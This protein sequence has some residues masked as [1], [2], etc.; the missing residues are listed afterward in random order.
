M[1][2]NLVRV[3]NYQALTNVTIMP[4]APVVCVF[5]AN[6]QGK[7]SL[8]DAIRHALTGEFSRV[9]LKKDLGQLVRDGAETGSVEV[10]WDGGMATVALPGGATSQTAALP[11][12]LLTLLLS[13]ERVAKMEAT[14]FR[15][16]LFKLAGLSA[17]PAEVRKKLLERGH[18]EAMVDLV[19]PLLRAGFDGAFAD[20]RSRARDAR[21]AWKGVTNETYG[22]KKAAGWE[23]PRPVIDPEA[24]AA[25]ER[26]IALYDGQVGQLQRD[27]GAV[28]AQVAVAE[29]RNRMLTQLRPTAKALER[30]D[31]DVRAI[32]QD[33]LDLTGKVDAVRSLA[34]GVRPASIK[35]PQPWHAPCPSCGTVLTKSGQTLVAY[36]R[37][38]EVA[39]AEVAA[40]AAEDLPALEETLRR[41]TDA[42]ATAKADFARSVDAVSQVAALE[43]QAEAVPKLTEAEVE[44]LRQ[45]LADTT[46]VRRGK[47]R[48]RDALRETVALRDAAD[49]RTADAKRW[50][51]AAVE[52]EAMA[53]ELSPD[54][55]PGEMLASALESFN[56]H[57]RRMAELSG[58]RQ[59]V[60][61]PDMQIRVSGRPYGLWS[62]SSRWRADAQLAA[63]VA[64]ASGVRLFALDE[65]DCLDQPERLRCLIWLHRLAEAKLID[66]AFLVGTLKG[67]PDAPVTFD[68]YWLAGGAIAEW[69]GAAAKA[70]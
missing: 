47:L 61:D 22:E 5:G 37:P 39:P 29:A 36:Q 45:N 64:I 8:L 24:G 66:T 33:V 31:I 54:G 30:R 49:R 46:D 57:L 43:A 9:S 21:S 34:A 7:T 41:R 19:Q 25:L 42:L 3:H 55:I 44:T 4:Q 13:P 48:D 16:F 53:G 23:A 38:Q 14:E 58:W 26:D 69:P 63:A 11:A 6:D 56:A 20:A 52:W 2:I 28:E 40:K 32:G 51:D 27:L 65:F 60:V 12:R 67:M 10:A 70:A 62:H 59:I 35:V 17:S 68:R 18:K 50:H 1:K 15:S